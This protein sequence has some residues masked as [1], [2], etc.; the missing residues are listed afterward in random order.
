MIISSSK[1]IIPQR[2]AHFRCLNRV[3]KLGGVQNLP[4]R[5][6]LFVLL[7]T[8]GVA[9]VAERPTFNIPKR[10]GIVVDGAVDEWGGRGLLIN[11]LA[12]HSGRKMP[13]RGDFSAKLP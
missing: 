2:V 1:P 10:E 4:I 13:A 6:I 8:M 9:S 7:M 12:P 3:Y 5:F 11:I